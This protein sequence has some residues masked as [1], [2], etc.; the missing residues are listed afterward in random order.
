[1][2]EQ[3]VESHRPKCRFVWRGS[4]EERGGG[5][6]GGVGGGR[7]GVGGWTQRGE[8]YEWAVRH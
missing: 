2:S 7:S 3:I 6:G 5:G 4:E 8:D 1:M